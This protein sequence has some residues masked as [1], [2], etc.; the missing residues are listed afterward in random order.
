MFHTGYAEM[1]FVHLPVIEVSGCPKGTGQSAAVTSDTQVPVDIH[2]S[3]PVP[4]V[5]GAGGTGHHAGGIS[6]VEAGQGEKGDACLRVS[7][8]FHAGHVPE[9]QAV[10]GE[11]VFIK[12]GHDAGHTTAAAG[13]IEGKCHLHNHLTS[14]IN[15]KTPID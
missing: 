11:I 5:D 6:A 14:T 1:T 3:V 15:H 7:P 4:L 9:T 12:A 2:N 13:D 8:L 10:A